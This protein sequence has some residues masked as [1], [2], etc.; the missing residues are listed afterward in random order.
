MNILLINQIQKYLE[1]NLSFH[2]IFIQNRYFLF[3]LKKY[4]KNLNF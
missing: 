4:F 1:F 3:I 2:F